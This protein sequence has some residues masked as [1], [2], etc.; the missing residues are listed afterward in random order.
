LEDRLRAQALADHALEAALYEERRVG[1]HP[2]G[3][4]RPRGS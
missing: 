2:G 3:G 1:I 4:R